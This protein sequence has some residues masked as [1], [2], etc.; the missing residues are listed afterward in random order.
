MRKDV[1][2]DTLLYVLTVCNSWLP[3]RRELR[4]A[5]HHHAQQGPIHHT[6]SS[7][8]CLPG[9]PPAPAYPLRPVPDHPT[10]IPPLRTFMSP[11][12]TS[13]YSV[14]LLSSTP[15]GNCTS[16]V[17]PTYLAG[18]RRR[19][20][21]AGGRPGVVSEGGTTGGGQHHRRADCAFEHAHA[22]AHARHAGCD[23]RRQTQVCEEAAW[24]LGSAW[25]LLL[26]AVIPASPHMM[27]ESV[28]LEEVSDAGLPL[29]LS[30]EIWKD[31]FEAGSTVMVIC[32]G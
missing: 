22:H 21:T 10:P 16:S 12:A 9:C 19:R 4:D 1:F 3:T 20:A 6:G 5:A 2:S 29:V 15:Y 24:S 32:G 14:L 11:L 17:M 7:P 28:M 25:S 13:V 26:H 18:R 27:T 30:Q 8:A 31:C 23:R